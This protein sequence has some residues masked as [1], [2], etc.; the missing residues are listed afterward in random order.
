[1][2]EQ[3]KIDIQ[4]KRVVV[5]NPLIGLL[6]MQVC[7]VADATDEE[8]LLV[9]NRDNPC[10][11]RNGWCYVVR[12]PEERELPAESAPGQCDEFPNRLHFLVGC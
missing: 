3:E 4:S 11:T 5:S 8:I 2:T 12:K 7:A 9:C 6:Y 10:G 1:M